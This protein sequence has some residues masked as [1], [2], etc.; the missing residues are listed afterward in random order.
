[1]GGNT[2]FANQYAAYDDLSGGMKRRL[3]GLAAVHHY[4][5]RNDLDETPHAAEPGGYA[6]SVAQRLAFYQRAGGIVTP[7][8]TTILRLAET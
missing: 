8:I 1:M 7:L 3:E 5:N 4:G 2:V 6:P